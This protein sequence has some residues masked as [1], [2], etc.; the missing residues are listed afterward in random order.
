MRSLIHCIPAALTLGTALILAHPAMAQQ[1]EAFLTADKS[2]DGNLDQGEFQVFIDGLAA[3]GKPMAQKLKAA[4]RYGMAFG[5]IDKNK[6]GLVS[7]TELTS[8]K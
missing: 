1:Q 4:G 6:D 3:A 2:G 8:L 5:R 7:P